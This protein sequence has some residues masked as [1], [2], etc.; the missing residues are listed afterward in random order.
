MHPSAW[1]T[2]SPKFPC[3]LLHRPLYRD[4]VKPLDSVRA[5]LA[6]HNNGQPA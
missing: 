6:G 2:C 3:R 5:P 4:E 1:N